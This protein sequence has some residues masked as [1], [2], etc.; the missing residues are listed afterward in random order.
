M[1]LKCD[2]L[3][4]KGDLDA[5][6]DGVNLTHYAGQ[7]QDILGSWFTPHADADI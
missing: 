6:D 3:V 2:I 1:H 5:V 7:G 4:S